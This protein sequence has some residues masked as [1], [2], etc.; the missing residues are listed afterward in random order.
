MY[1]VFLADDEPIV[2]E[3]IRN[4]IDWENSGFTFVGEATDGELALS[5]IH[6]IKPDILITDI[7]MPFMDGLELARTLRKIQPWI[8][9]IIL[10]GHDEFDYAKKAI[11]VGVED[12]I[13]KP[14]THE[15]LLA[16]LNKVAVSLDKER[17]QISDISRLK[18]ELESS[19]ILL[20]NSFLTDL[21]TGAADS[22]VMTDRASELGIDLI[23]RYYKIIISALFCGP[24]N[25]QVIQETKSRLLS[26]ANNRRDMIS[27][28]AEP[29]RLV[30]ILK[31]NSESEIEDEC[32]SVA[33][34]VE[35]LV[36][37]SSGCGVISVIGKTADHFSQI[38]GSYKDAAEIL[39]RVKSRNKS[40][41]LNAED[42]RNP[43]DASGKKESAGD[44]L[45]HDDPSVDKLKYAG[46]NE[47]DRMIEQYLNLLNDNEGQFNVIS[48]YLLVDL[49]V[50]VSKLVESLGG[51]VNDVMPE[52]RSA[53][54]VE[55]AGKDEASFAAEIRRVLETV[56]DWR[57]SK[58]QGKYGDVILR[59]KKYIAENYASQDIC[60]AS[61]ADEVHLSPNH[62]STIFSQECGITF[63]EYLTDVRV[64]SAKKLLRES[65]LK[66]A[67]IAYECGFSDPHYFSFIFK[68]KTGVSPREYKESLKNSA[69]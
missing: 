33:D 28:F 45:L 55:K 12:Y 51:T 4:K 5:M 27:F 10:S 52:L 44:I 61:V 26:Y 43:A 11:S 62:F 31:G 46:K 3:G 21:V 68:K 66:G 47:I 63:I 9:I 40:R 30:S 19:T 41:I 23:A 42:L 58:M 69:R 29:Q 64:E 18:E 16:S 17:K 6:D 34:A 14:F 32:F 35:H 50:S 15:E 53:A 56:L 36:A 65:G 38:S 59:A 8:R 20:R 13:L 1:S 67:D 7:K 48:S 57:D 39:S 25:R 22:S 2:L 60:L 49:I 54:F 24:E 37:Q